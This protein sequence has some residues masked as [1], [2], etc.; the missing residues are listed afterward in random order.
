MDTGADYARQ[1]A[2]QRYPLH[3]TMRFLSLQSVELCPIDGPEFFLGHE[4]VVD[5]TEKPS[6]TELCEG[7]PRITFAYRNVGMRQCGGRYENC[8]TGR[9]LDD[10]FEV[11][12]YEVPTPRMIKIAQSLY[13]AHPESAIHGV[14]V[15]SG[16]HFWA[17]VESGASKDA[18]QKVLEEIRF[19]L[20]ELVEFRLIIVIQ[21]RGPHR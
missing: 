6:G 1:V 19:L 16:P 20:P 18:L 8:G 3:P 17:K 15:S 9:E 12:E 5:I 21:V 2:E 11:G 4:M 7:G 14:S 13:R 10:H